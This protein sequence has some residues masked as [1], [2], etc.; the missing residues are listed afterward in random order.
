MSRGAVKKFTYR[1]RIKPFNLVSIKQM[2]NAYAARK[3][4]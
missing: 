1:D 4:K 2:E 3:L